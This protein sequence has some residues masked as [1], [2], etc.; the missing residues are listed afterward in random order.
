MTPEE[1]PGAI[2][3]LKEPIKINEGR[4]RWKVRV[5]NEGDRPIQV[6]A[7][8]AI[9]VYVGVRLTEIQLEQVGS[10]F[11][12]LETNRSL[13]FNRILAFHQKLRLDIPAGTAV[14]FEPGERKTVTLV[15]T[16]GRQLI[17]GGSGLAI[18]ARGKTAEEGET[19]VKKRLEE[20]GF[21]VSGVGEEQEESMDTEMNREVV[22]VLKVCLGETTLIVDT[23]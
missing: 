14:R 20:G 7:V 17:S 16:G 19:M 5:A 6:R 8:D 15:Q 21:A 9:Y 12:F 23:Y 13:S 18:A 10:H 1:L 3:C 4:Q 11:P 22:S 2:V